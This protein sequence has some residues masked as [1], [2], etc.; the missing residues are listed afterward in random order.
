MPAF[1]MYLAHSILVVVRRVRKLSILRK[2]V[3]CPLIKLS[4]D[5]AK[6]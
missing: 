4:S 5:N 1:A 6:R 2:E 3:D